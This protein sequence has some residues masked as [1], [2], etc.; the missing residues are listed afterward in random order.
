MAIWYFFIS[1]DGSSSNPYSVYMIET[2]ELSLLM[3]SGDEIK[4]IDAT[5][6]NGT[7]LFKKQRLTDDSVLIDWDQI[8]DPDSKYPNMMPSVER[9][10]AHMKSLGIQRN[11]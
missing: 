9:F 3:D 11:H 6:T 7:D 4:L 1:S 5:K 10:T 8:S 2:G